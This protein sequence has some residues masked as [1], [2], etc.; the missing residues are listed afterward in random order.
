MNFPRRR[1][2]HLVGASLATPFLGRLTWAQAWPSRPIRAIVPLAPGTGVDIIARLV[3]NEISG[4]LRQPIVVENRPGAGG[5]LGAAVVAKAVADGYTI[6]VESSTHTIVPSIY[7]NL[8]YD[9]VADFLPV[10]PL[11]AAPLVLLVAPSK[12]IKTIDDL[13]SV[14]KS[15]PDLL[16][17]ASAGAGSTTHLAAERLC[18]AA[19]FAAVHVPVRGGGYLPD[20]VAGR[21]DFAYGPVGACISLIQS[22]QLVA[23]A[24]ASRARTALLP[25]VP[26]TIEAGYAESDLEF[27]VGM[28]VPAKTPRNVIDRLHQVT[29]TVLGIPH[30]K[31]NLAAIGAEPMIMSAKEFDRMINKEFATYAAVVKSLGLKPI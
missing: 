19:G 13:V 9:P 15:K 18:L 28:F 26:T 31:Q 11:S 27:Y 7:A 30:L 17:F 22:G 5:T 23:L 24:V 10:A 21:I 4:E 12:A 8:P 14:G 2:F 3:L 1:F 25:N 29:S 16:T 20:L 6:L